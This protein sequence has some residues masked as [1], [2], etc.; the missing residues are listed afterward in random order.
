M[1]RK[2]LGAL[3]THWD[4]APSLDTALLHTSCD[5]RTIRLHGFKPLCLGF[6]LHAAAHIPDL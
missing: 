4:I 5:L 1:K 3:M 6:L 2:D